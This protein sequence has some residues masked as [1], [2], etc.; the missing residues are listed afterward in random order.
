MTGPL[1]GFDCVRVTGE[2]SLCHALDFMKKE[3]G[4][5]TDIKQD[6]YSSDSIP[7]ADKGIPGVNFIRTAADGTTRVHTRYDVISQV[8]PA[9]M[10]R[11][12]GFALEFSKRIINA[13]YFP[14]DRKLPPE[15]MEKVDKYLRKKPTK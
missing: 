14:I 13:A 8:D 6:I 2:A 11:T 15:I 1:L 10:A 7:F 9:K 5:A 3:I 4:Y 12:A